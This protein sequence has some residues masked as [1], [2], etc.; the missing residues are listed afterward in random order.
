[1]QATNWIVSSQANQ[2]TTNAFMFILSSSP[3]TTLPNI[4]IK[5]EDQKAQEPHTRYYAFMG[6][7]SVK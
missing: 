6:V 4:G 5:Q 1:M 7:I 2:A 3:V